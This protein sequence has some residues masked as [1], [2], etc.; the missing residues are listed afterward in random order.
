MMKM[1]L[2]CGFVFL[3]SL[4]CV[5]A[6]SDWA[7]LM[8]DAVM[9]FIDNPMR[10]SRIPQFILD[11]RHPWI[12]EN[13]RK[14]ESLPDAEAFLCGLNGPSD[15]PDVHVNNGLEIPGDLFHHLEIDNNRYGI[16]RPG[17]PNALRRLREMKRC[18]QALALVKTFTVNIYVH[19]QYSDWFLRV[20][21]P[22]R[23]QIESLKLFGDVL[24]AM[25]GL[26]TLKWELSAEHAHWF[27]EAFKHRDLT[28]PSPK[29]L[30]IGPLS[31]YLVGMCPNVEAI[32][33][34]ELTCWKHSPHQSPG[35][36]LV[37]STSSARNLTR[38]ALHAC[39]EGWTPELSREVLEYMPQLTSLGLKN[40]FEP[41]YIDAAYTLNPPR[42][43]GKLLRG[44]LAE[45]ANFPN[46]TH[47]DLPASYQLDLGF[48]GGP[49]CGNAYEGPD[50][51]RYQREVL[52][53]AYK[54]TELGG[55]IVAEVLPHLTSFT[56]GGY[57]P[58]ITRD[59]GVISNVTWPWTGHLD[60]WL[61]VRVPDH[62]EL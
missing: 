38:L 5:L 12:L 43:E 11:A 53:E 42:P 30:L 32:E 13:K 49:M 27:E 18:P 51:T 47:L 37:R 24:E 39:F 19:D 22:S 23:P 16:S 55:A 15:K 50:G 20:R 40:G 57:Q 45:L 8:P 28:L 9:D 4:T 2:V 34:I 48:D 17:W 58:N 3:S 60:E 31:H 46:L 29:H 10:R 21:E 25:T 54:A 35:L 44:V 26:E 62:D 7:E 52:A 61:M 6:W 1:W 36:L 59:E 33:D 41:M 56:I 14:L